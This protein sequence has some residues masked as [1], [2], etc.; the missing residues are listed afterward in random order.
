[1]MSNRGT[2]EAEMAQAIRWVAWIPTPG[3]LRGTA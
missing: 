2:L 1:M 3:R